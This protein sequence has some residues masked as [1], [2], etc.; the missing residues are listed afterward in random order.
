MNEKHHN[1][2]LVSVLFS[3]VVFAWAS[4]CYSAEQE[5]SLSLE[6]RIKNLED[7]WR[8]GATNEYY[9]QASVLASEMVVVGGQTNVTPEAA[10]LLLNLLSKKVNP[11]ER[12]DGDLWTMEILVRYLV[13]FPNTPDEELE[14]NA[15]ILSKFLGKIRTDRI[16]DYQWKRVTANVHPPWVDPSKRDTNRYPDT[17]P[18]RY[19]GMDP[20]AIGDPYERSLYEEA[21]RKN[22]ENNLLNGQ[23]RKLKDLEVYF[24]K[25]ILNYMIQAFSTNSTD[26]LE[27]CMEDAHLTEEEKTTVRNG[28]IEE[29]ARAAAIEAQ[30][31]QPQP[32][33]EMRR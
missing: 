8:A 23:Q 32:V 13:Y 28:I 2:V 21:I 6:Y 17:V 25:S 5:S 4:H 10:R 22:Q 16:P 31:E 12:G 20:A 27:K 26:L 11:L 30:I 29:K 14:P 33:R 1:S 15:V 18:F 7:I 9:N 3:V 24:S 19:S